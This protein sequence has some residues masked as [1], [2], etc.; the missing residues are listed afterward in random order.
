MREHGVRFA[1]VPTEACE[2]W[3]HKATMAGAQ[4]AFDFGCP[5]GWRDQ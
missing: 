1:D 2:A 3:S 5:L 4:T